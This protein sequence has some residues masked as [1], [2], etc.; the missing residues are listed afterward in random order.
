MTRR[1]LGGLG[2]LL[3]LTTVVFGTAGVAGAADPVT[4]P[5]CQA[6][7]TTAYP[8]SGGSDT[9]EALT[10]DGGHLPPGTNSGTATVSG[11]IPG[12][13]YCGKMFSQTFAVP[14]KTADASGKLVYTQI[15][16]PTG[17]EL[18]AAHH[19]DLYRAGRLVGSFDYCVNGNADIVS[20]KSKTCTSATAANSGSLPKTGFDRFWEILRVALVALAVGVLALYGRRRFEAQRLAA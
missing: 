4:D 9:L 11:G 8:P 16:V 5:A 2:A 17:F 18:N 10:L 15:A 13:T 1:F 7:V 19:L 3:C 14:N 20:L 12:L 6:T